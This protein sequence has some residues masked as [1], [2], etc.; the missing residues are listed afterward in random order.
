MKIFPAIAVGAGL[1]ALYYYSKL[2]LAG[3]DMQVVFKGFSI[4]GITNYTI[5][6]AVQNVSNS[7]IEVNSLAAD[8]TV[9]GNSIGNLSTFQKTDI[10]ANSEVNLNLKLNV[11]LLGLPSI[12]ADIINNQQG[13]YTVV[14][15]GN[16]NV[17]NIVVPLN[18]NDQITI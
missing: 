18:V 5:T 15:D 11:S 2:G 6:L 7:L 9:N 14:V 17:N 13:V 8:V 1:Y 12:I 3:R 10:P 4:Q 16:M